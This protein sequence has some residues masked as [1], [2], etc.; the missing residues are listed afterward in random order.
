MK[1]WTKMLGIIAIDEQIVAKMRG[2]LQKCNNAPAIPRAMQP[3]VQIS[4]PALISLDSP[5]FHYYFPY[6]INIFANIC[7]Y[8]SIFV[9]IFLYLQISLTAL[10]FLDSPLFHYWSALLLVGTTNICHFIHIF[11]YLNINMSELT[12]VT[13]VLK[14]FFPTK[15]IYSFRQTPSE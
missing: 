13:F 6:S 3:L 7:H 1:I 2:L 5:L 8:I 10:I 9:I 15:S 4:L 12:K 14:W 11:V